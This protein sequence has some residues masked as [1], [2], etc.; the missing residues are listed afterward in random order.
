MFINVRSGLKTASYLSYL[1][2]ILSIVLAMSLS[3]VNFPAAAQALPPSLTVNGTCSGN[4]SSLSTTFTNV[5]GDMPGAVS[6]RVLFLDGDWVSVGGGS[7]G[8]LAAGESQS[9]SYT[10]ANG[11]GNYRFQLVQPEGYSGQRRISSTC[12]ITCVPTPETPTP[13]TPTPETPTP[14]TP[15]PETPTPETPT[16]ETPTPETPTPVTP[17]TEVPTATPVTATPQEPTPTPQEPGITPQVP[18]ATPVTATP[19]E[20]TPTPQEP[21]ITPQVPTATPV[22]ATP[23]EPGGTPQEPT[24]Q[25]PVTAATNVP[26]TQVPTLGVPVVVDPPAVLIPVTGGDFTPLSPLET[27]QKL[28][29]NLGLGFVGLGLVLQGL[30]RRF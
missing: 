14:E 3:L 13:E 15:T 8:P 21:G 6:Y 18:T 20:P 16:P 4:C 10:P 2:G 17:T 24:P 25:I 29:F 22:T 9:V 12:K 19:Q 30:R 11:S 23:Q 27:A 5:G 28:V 7:I 1:L 26:P